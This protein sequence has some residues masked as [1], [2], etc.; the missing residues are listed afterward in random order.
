MTTPLPIT[1]SLISLAD[2]NTLAATFGQSVT[3]QQVALAELTISIRTGAAITDADVIAD[4]DASDRYWLAQA[5]VFQ[6]I[7]QKSQP[8][9]LGRIDA[10][11]SETDGD[12]I[13]ANHDG[14]MLAPLAKWAILRTS[15]L[16]WG[17]AESSPASRLIGADVPAVDLEGIGYR[18]WGSGY[19]R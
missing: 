1:G 11:Q 17:T 13:T 16:T 5:I 6:A 18:R 9:L 7:W 19:F 12:S 4:M 15:L 3:A 8:D 10:T 2:A 14:L